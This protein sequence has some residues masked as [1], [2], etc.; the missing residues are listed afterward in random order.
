M[1]KAVIFDFDLTLA[2]TLRQKIKLMRRFCKENHTS[3]IKILKNLKKLFG[4]SFKELAKEYSPYPVSTAMEMYKK[5]FKQ[6]ANLVKFNGK[7]AL[8]ELRKKG[9]KT[10]IVS[11]EFKENIQIVLRNERIKTDL[12]LSTI[13]MKKTKPDP[14]PLRIAMKRLKV[15]PKEVI[16][17]GDHPRDIIMGKRAGVVTVGLANMLHTKKDLKKYHPDHIIK[18][19]SE[20]TE[21]VSAHK[22]N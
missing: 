8:I 5:A 12:L 4:M 13:T 15:K 10:A 14:L 1:I 2:N 6:T 18:K 17:I 9:Y 11:N 22:N 7:K 16:Y 21:L 20:I 3:L 19:I